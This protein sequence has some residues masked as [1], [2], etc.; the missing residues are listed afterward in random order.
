MLTLY[1]IIYSQIVKG[2]KSSLPQDLCIIDSKIY[3]GCEAWSLALKEKYKL[4]L[5]ENNYYKAIKTNR[6]EE[7]LRLYQWFSNF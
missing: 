1:I 3:S 6:N 5:F 7:L 4:T 2:L